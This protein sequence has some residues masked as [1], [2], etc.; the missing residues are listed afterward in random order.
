MIFD[1]PSFRIVFKRNFFA[2]ALLR[3]FV[4]NHSRTSPS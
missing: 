4:T 3:R 1:N 2:A